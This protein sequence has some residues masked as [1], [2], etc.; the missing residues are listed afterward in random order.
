MEAKTNQIKD[1]ITPEIAHQ[2][3]EEECEGDTE[4]LNQMVWNH[5]GLSTELYPH[6]KYS[7]WTCVDEIICNIIEKSRQF[8]G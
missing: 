2:L 8:I 4:I 7:D 6:P 5:Y 1:D 3:F